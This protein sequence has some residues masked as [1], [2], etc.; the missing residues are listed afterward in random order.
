MASSRCPNCRRWIAPG[1]ENCDCHTNIG[2][3]G[4]PAEGSIA[5]MT[6]S[7][8]KPV[9]ERVERPG[10]F[11]P[12]GRNIERMAEERLRREH[13]T[14]YHG[15]GGSIVNGGVIG[16]ALAMIG[17]VIWFF[18]GIVYLD[19]IYFYP[20]ILFVFGLMGVMKGVMGAAR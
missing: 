1:G 3:S 10:D 8:V 7:L 12:R 18:A 17:A 15:Q 16:G 4:Y 14:D 13:G 20:P 2:P 6:A 5:L 11:R 19:M 9:A